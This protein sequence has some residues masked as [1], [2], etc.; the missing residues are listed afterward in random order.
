[1]R[2]TKI[3]QDKEN[4]IPAEVIEQSIVDVAKGFRKMNS[5][6]LSRKAIV[7]LVQHAVGVTRINQRQVEDVLDAAESLDTKYLKKVSK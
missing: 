5:T 3:V 7:L 1:M 4:P 2:T 6:R